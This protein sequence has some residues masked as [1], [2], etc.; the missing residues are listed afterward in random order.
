MRNA[1]KSFF[2]V[3]IM[4]VF[5]GMTSPASAAVISWTTWTA[6]TSGATTGS[7]T[8]TIS[9]LGIG[10]SYS[11]EFGFFDSALNWLPASSFTGGTVDNAPPSGVGVLNDGIAIT[12]GAGTGTNTVTFGTPV[13]DPIL[14]I[15]SL[16]NPSFAANFTFPAGQTFSIQ[17]SGPNS[18][19]GGA[20]IFSG[21]TCPA[22][23][24][25]GAEGNGV[26]Q[27]TGTFSSISWTNPIAEF[28]YAFTIGV[29][30]RDGTTPP[31]PEPATLAL[32]GT[33]LAAAVYRRRAR[34]R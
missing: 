33:A 6:G 15:W 16:G 14:A 30:G 31:V 5:A 22:L 23:A 13:V 28:Y 11:G 7:A 8:G 24:V 10:V 27:F 26:V 29:A 17:G 12:G 21:G 19:F 34:R 2:A 20:A 9:G 4:A 18:E 32:L 1:S 3:L 25:C